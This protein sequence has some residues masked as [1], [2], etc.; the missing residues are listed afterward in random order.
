ME[1][2]KDKQILFTKEDME[3]AI[4]I[5]W[6]TSYNVESVSDWVE[7]IISQVIDKKLNN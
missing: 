2:E 1:E 7:D 6:R 5:A 4:R 3:I